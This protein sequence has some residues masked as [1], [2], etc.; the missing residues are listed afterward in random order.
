ME[1]LPLGNEDTDSS[2]TFYVDRRT[3]RFAC[4]R[5]NYLNILRI[6]LREVRDGPIWP[7][8]LLCDRNVWKNSRQRE[9]QPPCLLRSH[10][11]TFYHTY[12]H[13]DEASCNK[14]AVTRFVLQSVLLSVKGIFSLIIRV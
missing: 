11:R 5:G 6:I 2:C 10:G 1:S 13:R 14:Q 12:P 3:L 7:R 9:E 4:E 8:L